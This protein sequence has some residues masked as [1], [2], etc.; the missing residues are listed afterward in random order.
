[1]LN[2]LFWS[3]VDEGWGESCFIWRLKVLG[4]FTAEMCGCYCTEWRWSKLFS[5][6]SDWM[7]WCFPS[8]IISYYF[9]LLRRLK[10]LE[11]L[12]LVITSYEW[13][14][15]LLLAL[16]HWLRLDR[17]QLLLWLELQVLQI[18]NRWVCALEINFAA[19]VEGFYVLSDFSL[20]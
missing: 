7:R 1:M 11:I 18:C 9:C 4:F 20:W 19:V 12:L 2:Y 8:V 6:P 3:R 10:P 13:I 14:G 5:L 17:L 15:F 16:M